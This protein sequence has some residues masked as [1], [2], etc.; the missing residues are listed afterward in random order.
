MVL[1]TQTTFTNGADKA[2][3]VQ[4]YEKTATALLGSTAKLEYDKLEWT[5]EDFIA[6]GEALRYCG[7]SR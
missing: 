6:L 2:G 3:V 1:D 4:L 7:V 5:S